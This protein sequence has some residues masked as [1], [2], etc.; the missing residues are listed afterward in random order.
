M[1]RKV[2]AAGIIVIAVAFIAVLVLVQQGR[3]PEAPTE[4]VEKQVPETAA[5]IA[6]L[7]ASA[8]AVAQERGL[9]PD[10]IT[11]ALKTYMCSS[12]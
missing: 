8:Q 6:K 2:M 5:A 7:P 3:G 9:S 11:A 1:D 4:Q 12:T 10:D